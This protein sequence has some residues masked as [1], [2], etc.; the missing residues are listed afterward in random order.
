[1][2]IDPKAQEILDYWIG[3]ADASPEAAATQGARWFSGGEEVDREITKR[4][5]EILKRAEVGELDSWGIDPREC[6]ALIILLDQFTRNIYRGQAQAFAMDDVALALCLELQ[7]RNEFSQLGPVSR[8]FALM[9]MQHSEDLDIQEAS[10][11][12]FSELADQA[13]AEWKENLSGNLE[14]AVLH[15]DIVKRF[16]RFPHRNRILGREA[17][18]EEADWLNDGAPTFGQG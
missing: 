4:F 6:M 17:T 14:F 5:G 1:M 3:D 2:R 10:V 9:P 13:S 8:V 16:G 11:A 18:A 12:R 7:S 15:R